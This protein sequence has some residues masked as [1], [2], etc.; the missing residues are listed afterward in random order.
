MSRAAIPERHAGCNFDNFVVL[1]D[2]QKRALAI[3]RQYAEQFASHRKS[4]ASLLFLG[5][6]GTGKNHLSA[7]I[8]KA[9]LTQGFSVLHATAFEVTG[10]I[11]AT[12][13]KRDGESQRTQPEVINDFASVDLLILDEVG[14]GV[15]P[16]VDAPLLFSVIDQRYQ[17][18][19]PTLVISNFGLDV[20]EQWLT[21][22]GLDRLREGGGDCVRFDWRS[23]RG[24]VIS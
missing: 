5:N 4:G 19:R 22:P 17:Q 1:H 7:A 8:G 15:S 3:A 11:K 6:Q 9:I 23:V 14:R 13:S 10:K 2:G 24:C 21:P 18:C 20:V 16:R 12:W